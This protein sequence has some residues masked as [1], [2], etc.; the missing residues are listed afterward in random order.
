MREGKARTN[1]CMNERNGAQTRFN[2]AAQLLAVL[3]QR[4]NF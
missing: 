2:S 1:E 3:L 4:L